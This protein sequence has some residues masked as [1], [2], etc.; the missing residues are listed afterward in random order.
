MFSNS[1]VSRNK[2]FLVIGAGRFGTAVAKTL[3]ELGNDVMLIDIKNQKLQEAKDISIQSAVLDA[4]DEHALRSLDI[5]SFDTVILAI[6]KNINASIL[7]TVLLKELNANQIIC[8][9]V[10]DIQAKTLYKIGADRV[11][12][13]ERDTGDRLAHCLSSKNTFDSMDISEKFS[14]VEITTPRKWVGKNIST[15]NLK[16][17]YNTFILAI[18]NKDSQE[19]NISRNQV[20]S[21]DDILVLL[22]D[23]SKINDI[24]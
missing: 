19:V 22:A 2:D 21:K 23:K 5:S 6:G 24:L 11:V 14:L 17:K 4:T 10:S 16:D 9:A 1:K 15:L 7:I 3:T 18:K 12:F 13:P 20:I 8:K